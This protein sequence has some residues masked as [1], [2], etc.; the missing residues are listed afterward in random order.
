M[1]LKIPILA[2]LLLNVLGATAQAVLQ[3]NKTTMM[4]ERANM[5][6]LP[7]WKSAVMYEVFVR[8]F[9]DGNA[10]GIGDLKGLTQNLEYI[11]NLGAD[12]MWMMPISP[13]SSYHKYDVVDYF[14][15]DPEYGTMEDFKRFVEKSHALGMRVVI[16]LVLNHCG[17]K[18]P[19]FIDASGNKQSKYRDWF[20]W[21]DTSKITTEKQNWYYPKGTNGKYIQ[22]EKYYGFFWSEM[23]DWNFD[24]PQVEAYMISIGKHWLDLGVDGFRLDAAQHLYPNVS[25]PKTHAFWRKFR[26]TMQGIKPDFYMVGEVYNAKSVVAPYLQ[27]GMHAAFNF[28]L[29]EG[30]CKSV[31][32][33]KD[34]GLVVLQNEILNTYRGYSG[35]FIDATFITNHDQNRIGTLVEGKLSH[36]KLAAAILLTLPGSPYIYYGEEI[37]M[38]GKK[39]D[40][41][42]REPFIWSGE[43]NKTQTSW[44]KPIHST[45]KD[46]QPLD[47]QMKDE[48]SMY[49]FYK[50]WIAFRKQHLEIMNGQLLDVD[51]SNKSLLCYQMVNNNSS[52]LVVHNLSGSEVSVELPASIVTADAPLIANGKFQRV[53]DKLTIAAH[54]S[55]VVEVVASEQNKN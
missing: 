6:N 12:G 23:P 25:D 8:S 1:K 16:D 3:D 7:S 5:D 19:Y 11:K 26:K 13:A 39:P 55:A 44:L 53:N 36:M 9:A 51:Q 46:V 49:N 37:G 2:L 43:V 34:S 47:G 4:D 22:G 45:P 24:N 15:I 41:N 14:G 30:I 20:V 52:Y 27:G 35:D 32:N 21:S 31:V 48:S 38:L 10:D 17:S 33:G 28:D 54:G 50:K 42:I 29:A 40:E 18:H